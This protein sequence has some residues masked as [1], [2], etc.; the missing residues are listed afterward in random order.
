[1]LHWCAVLLVVGGIAAS[2][3]PTL[4]V[5]SSA[6]PWGWA[7][8]FVGSRIPA[9]LANVRSEM[10]LKR[11]ASSHL[12]SAGG[13]RTV[14]QA[15]LWTALIGLLL[16]VPS[17]LA[18]LLARGQPAASLIADYRSGAECLLG[19]SWN[20]TAAS[21]P[22]EHLA[23]APSAAGGDC[24]HA[25]VA[26]AAFALPGALFAVSE[27]QV[28]Q[29][30]SAATYFLL[31]AVELPVQT[32]ALSI[33]AVMGHLASAHRASFSYGLPITVA[34]LGLWAWAEVRASADERKAARADE[35]LPRPA[36]ESARPPRDAVP[37]HENL[38]PRRSAAFEPLLPD[39]TAAPS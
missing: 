25:A 26:V 37:A 18:L 38:P 29:H 20:A 12:D 19:I 32:I 11:D 13:V 5:A 28:V 31:Q 22:G 33:P 23:E 21:Q 39:S 4:G 14:L 17:S 35:R 34:G 36:D 2:Y 15:G 1:V 8:L 10:T 16:N 24:S 30:A 3:V 6:V 9:A 27:F 7:A